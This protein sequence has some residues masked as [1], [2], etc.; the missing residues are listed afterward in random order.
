MD[1]RIA[2]EVVEIGQDSLLSSA[3]EATR[4]WRRTERAI[5]EKNPST[6]LSQEP[7]LGVKTKLKRPLR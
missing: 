7:C 2:I 5:F 3:F 6:R 1:N 4:I